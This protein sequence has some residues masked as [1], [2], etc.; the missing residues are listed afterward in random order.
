MQR[1]VAPRRS[2][3]SLSLL[4]AS[5]E[6]HLRTIMYI[7]SQRLGMVV[8]SPPSGL[9]L[10]RVVTSMMNSADF[11]LGS[12]NWDSANRRS[13]LTCSTTVAC[14]RSLHDTVAERLR[15]DRLFAE[16]RVRWLGVV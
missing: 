9:P 11:Y 14:I 16:F 5:S 6:L 10:P 3:L 7:C 4:P 1:C 13:A 15:A 12:R 8:H 2:A